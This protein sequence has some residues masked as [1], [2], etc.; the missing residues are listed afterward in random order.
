MKEN[1]TESAAAR[2]NEYAG[3]EENASLQPANVAVKASDVLIGEAE[4]ASNETDA[5]SAASNEANP[6][7]SFDALLKE[8]GFRSEFDRRISRALET[9]RG[10]WAQETGAKI[11]Q[12]RRE[13]QQ[14]ALSD[15]RA[16][17]QAEYARREVELQARERLLTERELRADAARM[18]GERGLPPELAGA[19]NYSGEE[20]M[21]KSMEAAELAFRAAVQSGVEQRMRGSTPHIAHK[22][23]EKEMGDAEYYRS[24][25]LGSI[26]R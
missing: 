22:G 18:L 16:R 26:D 21:K 19:I 7:Q 6:S 20:S 3:A 5:A 24:R 13:A 10:K 23:A 12:A 4:V 14:L 25:Y 8:R 11:E 17:A 15:S 2:R 1:L 9:A